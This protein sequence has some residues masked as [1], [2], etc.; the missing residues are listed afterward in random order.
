MRAPDVL[1]IGAMKAGTTSLYEDLRAH[2]NIAF[3]NGKEPGHLLR[4]DVGTDSGRRAMHD[5]IGRVRDGVRI[6]DA[7]VSYAMRPHFGDV[8]T[9]ALA[10]CPSH[11]RV[12]YLVRN[13]I[14]R[15]ISHHHYDLAMGDCSGDFDREFRRN[16]YFLD[17]G[18]YAYQL[19]PWLAAFGP[20]RVLVL[21]FEDFVAARAE[22]LDRVLAFL[23]MGAGAPG[24][25]AA[26]AAEGARG[27]KVH[28]RTAELRVASGL[29]GVVARSAAYR[30]L[31]RPLV[32]E[33]VRRLLRR[34]SSPAPPPRPA[35]PSP[36]TLS[37][38]IEAYEP[39]QD[40]L[41]GLLGGGAP[42]WDLRATADELRRNT[43][44]DPS[45]P[46]R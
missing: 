1:L 24:A 38:M 27:A 15:A 4:E 37:R 16:A 44:G 3:P 17:G 14:H 36:A 19:E 13:P 6:G 12:L 46:A 8:P 33:G 43:G 32:P 26:D 9:R 5:R 20:D 25:A 7:T 39:E 41:A 30:R 40:R 34:G 10:V 45:H 2:P 21:R 29:G 18:R 23:G 22:H 35:P 11:A 28:H 31:V 42:R